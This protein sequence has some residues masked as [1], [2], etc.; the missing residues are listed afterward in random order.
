[1]NKIIIKTMAILGLSLAVPSIAI[2]ATPVPP[3][4]VSAAYQALW[5]KGSVMEADGVARLAKAQAKLAR[6][7]EDIVK[8]NSK[9]ADASSESTLAA[10][11]YANLTSN[12]PVAAN[13][14]EA[15]AFAKK[16]SDA[17]KRWLNA[18]N[19]NK[20]GGKDLD[21][22]TRSKATAEAEITAAQ[23]KIDQGRV[24]MAKANGI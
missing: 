9:Q 24:M 12:I 8:A 21:K 13:S 2:A 3:S 20:G 11:D 17:A 19:K 1:M 7:N 23:S 22:A 16:L 10:A 18:D 4:T 5:I 6:A 15:S 14:T